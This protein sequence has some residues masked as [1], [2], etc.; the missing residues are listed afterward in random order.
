MTTTATTARAIRPLR[1]LAAAVAAAVLNLA[2]FLIGARTGA[3]MIVDNPAPS[4]IGP[5]EV[6]GAS[7]GPLIVAG[8]ATWLLARKWPRL[9]VWA[10]WAGAALA[11]VTIA[12]PFLAADDLATAFTL[13]AMHLVS[14]AAWL[15]V[16]SPWVKPVN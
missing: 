3:S 7:L 11:V 14:G 6:I 10:G 16:T 9:R 5:G 2:A 8:L 12:S 1:L 15:A 4:E 13:A